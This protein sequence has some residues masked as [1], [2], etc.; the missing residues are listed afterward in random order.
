VKVTPPAFNRPTIWRLNTGLL[1]RQDLQD[2]TAQLLEDSGHWDVCKVLARSIARDV[3]VVASHERNR[4]IHRLQRQ[5]RQAEKTALAQRRSPKTDP[6]S[7]SVRL[8]LRTQLDVAAERAILRARVQ[9]RE[10]SERSS[11]YFFSRHRNSRITSRLSKLRDTNG[12]DFVTVAARTA[13]I[14][15][16]YS[17]LY[18]A[19]QHDTTACH[20]FLSPLTLPRLGLGEIHSLSDPITAEELA[21]VVRKLPSRKSPGPDGLPY[22][23]YRTYLP[24]LSPILLDL[25]NGIL[26]GDDPPASWSA[27]TLTLLPKPGRNHEQ[28]RNWRPITLLNC[29]AKIFSRILANRLATILP[30]LLHPDQSGFVR[31]RSAPDVAMTIKTVLAH[32][33][34]HQIDGA[35]A[36]LDQEKAYDRVAHPYLLA[37]LERFGF[38]ASLARVFYNTSGPSHSFILDDGHPLPAVTVACGVR[39]GD[40]LAPLLFNLAME[41][42]LCA[43]R[44][45]LQGVTL[46]WGSFKTG[47]FADDLTAGLSQTDVPVLQE[48]LVD[49]G[50]A[51]NGRVNFDKSVILDLSG[52]A[53]TPQWIVASGVP[54]HDHQQPLRVLGFDLIRSP[55]GVQEDWP[56]LF[57]SMRS[58]AL[59]LRSR[60]CALQGRVLLVNS[61]V[62]SKL[63]Y[64]T[65]L[66]SPSTVQLRDFKALA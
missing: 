65:R 25:Y 17:R 20:S 62:L 39:Q 60:S 15:D 6:E 10:Q 46:P 35:L 52:S 28:L 3:A 1:N 36:F 58:V 22:E 56:A 27:T 8:A 53:Q 43:L 48:V 40:P 49:Y 12:Q 16:F 59:S 55:S 13:H 32:A 61:M 23:W 47:A 4:E 9:W 57:D 64:K 45:R 24:F 37:V 63:W 33:A 66:S 7:C 26:S 11:Y 18:E 42:L 21:A 2:S 44:L 14:R 54:V 19:P 41:P 29:D 5:L 34:S 31:G 50:R 38:P 30:R 51:S